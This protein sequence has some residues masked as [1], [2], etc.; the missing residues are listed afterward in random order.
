[1]STFVSLMAIVLNFLLVDVFVL[2]LCIRLFS[3]V[4]ILCFDISILLWY[5]KFW[6]S[7]GSRKMDVQ[8]W[9]ELMWIFNVLIGSSDSLIFYYTCTHF[10]ISK[11]YITMMLIVME[12]L[13][14]WLGW[15]MT[16]SKKLLNSLQKQK[17]NKNSIYISN[18]KR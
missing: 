11:V 7:K 5:Y 9:H 16:R 17:N 15:N 13:S 8:W 14:T 18:S 3:L 6:L 12:F 2:L 1:M 4:S 10:S